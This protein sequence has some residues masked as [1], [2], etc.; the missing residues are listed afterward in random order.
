MWRAFYLSGLEEF[1]PVLRGRYSRGKDE[2]EKVWEKAIKARAFDTMRGFLPSGASTN[3][4]WTGPLRQFADRVPI[5]RHHPLPEVREVGE[6]IEKALLKAFPNSFSDKRYDATEKYLEE[7]G[8]K[9]AYFHDEHAVDFTFT[10]FVEHKRLAEY[11]EA[12][13]RRPPKTELPYALRDAGV[14]ECS[15]LLDFGSFRDIQRH[16]AISLRMPLL[17]DV[18]GFE[19]W[20]LSELPDPL[21]ARAK[22]TIKNQLAAIKKLGLPDTLRQYYLP[23]GFRTAVRFT[24]DLRAL[25][26]LVEIRATRFVHPTLRRRAVQIAQALQGAYEKDGLVLHL[27]PEPDRFD[28]KRGT[29]DIVSKE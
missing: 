5:L 23:M 21:R 24:G 9:Y 10:D 8:E 4:V 27:D 13:I 28:V 16:R 22:E 17:T 18:H 11:R 3:L 6:T 14:A 19:P 25:V 12:L 29:H 15:F 1:I 2:D 7:T 20:Y 26:Y